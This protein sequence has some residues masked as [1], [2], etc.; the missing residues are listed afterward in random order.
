MEEFN[1]IRWKNILR[2]GTP[3]DYIKGIVKD[4][5][6]NVIKENDLEEF[7]HNIGKYKKIKE[8][9]LLNEIEDYFYKKVCI[10]SIMKY[11]KN[12][13]YPICEDIYNIAFNDLFKSRNNINM[14]DGEYFN[15]KLDE[16]FTVTYY[17]II[18]D[19]FAEIKLSRVK[20]ISYTNE[21]AVE[22]E[23]E[24]CS[25]D[26]YDTCKFVIDLKNR[27]VFMFYNDVVI[28][29]SV[30]PREITVKKEA[31]RNLFAGVSNKNILKYNIDAYLK[32]YFLEYMKEIK[33][34]NPCKLISVI[35][36]LSTDKETSSLKSINYTYEHR[37]SRLE[38]VEDDILNYGHIVAEIESNING[39][40]INLKN[41]GEITCINACF[42]KEVIKDV[43]KEFF[44][45]YTFY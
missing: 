20:N 32:E 40:M 19:N 30:D 27:L 3:F 11:K 44:N 22:G 42:D 21:V 34:D 5:Y 16:F 36:T 23:I 7:I 25:N 9:D 24:E 31:F 28:N 39:N 6:G 8:I 14:K 15:G 2:L 41:D 18:D 1:E 38:A 12:T 13:V 4:I 45:N 26:I 17:R 43:C 35:K 29:E 10:F 37:R 33:D